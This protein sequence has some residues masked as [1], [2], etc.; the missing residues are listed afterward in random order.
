MTAQQAQALSSKPVVVVPSKTVPQGISALL[1]LNPHADLEHNA[2][3][4]TAALAHVET[5][6]VTTAVHDADFDGIHV[7]AGDVIGLHNDALTARGDS[8]EAVVRELLAQMGAGNLE[9]ITL[10]HGQPVAVTE[11]EALQA[12]LR[13]LYPD[14]EIEIV[15]GGQPFYHYII[16]AE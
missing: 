14:Q 9:I 8:S 7:R 2:A 3:N 12:E 16:S 4:M 5:G 1:A 15:D 6:E 10:Y 11:A 13:E